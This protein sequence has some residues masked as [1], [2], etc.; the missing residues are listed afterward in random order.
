MSEKVNNEIHVGLTGPVRSGK[1]NLFVDFAKCVELN[2]HGFPQRHNIRIET[3]R[4]NRRLL[5]N[6]YRSLPEATE[7]VTDVCF[8][9]DVDLPVSGG[10]LETNNFTIHVRDAPGEAVFPSQE[11]E[12]GRNPYAEKAHEI[13]EWFAKARGIVLVISALHASTAAGFE[14][15]IDK[16]EDFLERAGKPEFEQLE[17]VVIA[18]SMF[19]LLLLR[20]GSRARDVVTAPEAILSILHTHMRPA[21]DII[22]DF[23]PFPAQAREIDLRFIATSSYGFHPQLGSANIDPAA[24]VLD[25]ANSRFPV[26]I[27]PD[28]VR[29]PYMTADPF[30]FAAIGL[31]S[32]Y[33]FTRDEILTGVLN[34]R[35]RDL[36]AVADRP[37][38]IVAPDTEVDK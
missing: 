33:L 12:E 34:T 14:A 37:I 20:F 38:P 29:Y 10:E 6:Y 30:I 2:Y 8:D 3:D 31:D 28:N 24:E 17:R 35:S 19:D 4:A 32:P 22:K 15:L 11:F 36:S 18:I 21:F 23:R 26:P 5:R 9:L 27:E 13:D 16:V 25:P 7:G 1:T